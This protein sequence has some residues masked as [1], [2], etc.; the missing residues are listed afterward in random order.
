MVH[1]YDDTAR[2]ENVVVSQAKFINKVIADIRLI[3]T[4]S[5]GLADIYRKHGG[6]VEPA[7]KEIKELGYDG[8]INPHSGMVQVMRDIDTS[9]L[10]EGHELTPKERRAWKGAL[11][12]DELED[13]ESYPHLNVSKASDITDADIEYVASRL[14]DDGVAYFPK[15]IEEQRVA[16]HFKETRSTSVG[17]LGKKPRRPQFSRRVDQRELA[18][19]GP[20]EVALDEHEFGTLY[21]PN[22]RSAAWHLPR[23]GKWERFL[24]RWQDSIVQFQRLNEVIESE[25]YDIADH[26]NT[27]LQEEVYHGKTQERAARVEAKYMVP[28]MRELKALIKDRTETRTQLVQKFE[29][30]LQ[31]RHTPERNAHIREAYVNRRITQ[32]EDRRDKLLKRIKEVTDEAL[33]AE[34]PLH[35]ERLSNTLRWYEGQLVNI[36]KEMER[37][38]NQK[39]LTSGMTD[40]QAAG[41]M[42]QTRLDGLD[43]VFGRMAAKYIDRMLKERLD[44]LLNEGLITQDEYNNVAIY[45]YYVPLKYKNTDGDLQELLDAYTAMR[46]SNGFDIRGTELPFVTGMETGTSIHPILAA[47]FNE[48][49]AAYDRVERNKVSVSLLEMAERF[50]NENIWEVNKEVKKRVFDKK[51]GTIKEADDWWARNQANVIAAKRD[52]K[53]FFVTLRDPGLIEAMKGLGVENIN[54]Y[55]RALRVF[56]RTLAQLYT[57]WSP[58][59]ILTNFARDWQQAIVSAST[60]MSKESARRIAMNS[61]KAVRGILAANFPNRYP[62]LLGKENEYTKAYS[63]FKEAG[64]K[65]GFFG[66]RG[67]EDM[68]KDLLRE[69]STSGAVRTLRGARRL[70][71]YISSI[72]E[73]T[74]N[75]IRLAT[76]VEARRVGASKDV[77]ASLAKNVTVNFNRR[78]DGSGLM[79]AFYLFFNAGV[80][81]VNRFFRSMQTPAGQRMAAMTVGVSFLLHTYTRA[82]MG[83]DDDGEDLYDKVSPFINGRHWVIGYAEGKYATIPMPYGFGVWGQLGK[84]LEHL[85]FAGDDRSKAATESAARM[86]SGLTTHFSPVGETSF[87]QGAYAMARPLIPTVIEP[88]ADIL[89]NETY[90]GGKVYPAKTPWDQRADSWRTYPARTMSDKAA[91][92]ATRWLNK[93]TGGSAYRSGVLD[94]NADAM[95]YVLDSFIG[96]TGRFV[97]RPFELTQKWVAGEDDLWNDWIIL[98]RFLGETAPQY[99]VPGEFYDAIADVGSAVEEQE[100]MLENDMDTSGWEKRHGWKVGLKKAASKSQRTIRGLRKVD[101]DSQETRDAVLQVQRDFISMYL[102]AGRR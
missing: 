25:G 58:E 93:I 84:E 90:W 7:L 43:K 98:R 101:P 50:P 102:N 54:K 64:G 56:I 3:P 77:A 32:L 97:K 29:D 82:I 87:D 57:T 28:L 19:I 48:T 95:T 13:G 22:Y 34:G 40:K 5:D 65:V 36:E 100:W 44:V 62:W 4:D 39:E 92:G 51:T 96:P 38:L 55:V 80:Q 68:H 20:E 52:G 26:I 27:R 63:E 99:Y 31:A 66:M 30:F 78:G 60:D 41:V 14:E 6:E 23:M 21:S 81:G 15:D 10:V 70:G 79:G 1:L 2:P 46:S 75:G 76:Y 83:E 37:V 33:D 18:P 74:E 47:A 69:L 91:Q 94:F 11:K 73:A 8:V 72:N 85:V 89:A 35:E 45:K 9:E 42:K 59:F 49:L 53:T 12:I 88:F 61:H 67:I 16:K 17:L 24:K 86:L 71:D